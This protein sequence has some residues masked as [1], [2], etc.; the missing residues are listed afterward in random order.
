[1]RFQNIELNSSLLTIETNLLFKFK[2]EFK[3]RQSIEDKFYDEKKRIL[4]DGMRDVQKN[5]R[6]D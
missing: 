4:E 1:M 3:Q 5:V 6:L 2:Q